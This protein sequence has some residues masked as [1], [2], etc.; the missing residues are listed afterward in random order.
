MGSSY[1][2][3]PMRNSIKFQNPRRRI[4]DVSKR[5]WDNQVRAT[6]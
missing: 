4:I 1:N 2:A 5:T 3:E 6:K